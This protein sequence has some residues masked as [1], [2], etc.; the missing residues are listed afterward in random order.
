M[1][2]LKKITKK[3]KLR[4]LVSQPRFER[5]TLQY[6]YKLET[7]AVGGGGRR[8]KREKIKKYLYVLFLLCM[9]K[10]TTL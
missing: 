4:Y 9:Q 3:Y 10:S 1:A 5:A 8:E 2:E 7:L 6:A